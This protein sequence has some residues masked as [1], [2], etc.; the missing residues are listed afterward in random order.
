[1]NIS[2][3]SMELNDIFTPNG[4]PTATYV[5][6]S[7]GHL[8]KKLQQYSQTKNIVVS[9]SG[10][11][12]TGKTVLIRKVL[13][14][15]NAILIPGASI[16][17]TNDFY[18]SAFEWLDIQ[19]PTGE[20]VS[21]AEGSQ[22]KIGATVKVDAPYLGGA[23]FSGEIGG[24]GSIN[25]ST[26]SAISNNPFKKLVESAT[27]RNSIIFID[28]FHYIPTQTQIELARI[29]KALA[30]NGVRIFTASVPHRAE[31]VVRANPELRGRFAGIDTMIWQLDELEKIAILG[32]EALNVSIDPS[33]AEKL[34]VFA[35][36]SPQIMH[37]LCLNLCHELGIQKN[38]TLRRKVNISNENIKNMLAATAD[39]T[40]SS[41]LIETLH[42]GPKVKGQPRMQYSFT[43][44]T[45]GDVY[46][47]ILLGIS[48]DPVQVVFSYDEI[49]N[50]V[51]NICKNEYPTGQSISQSLT[52]LHK[53]VNTQN[54]HQSYFE[55]DD[56]NLYITDPHLAFYLR[57]SSKIE[58]LGTKI[59]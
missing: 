39:F 12:K 45:K 20:T 48:K 5:A 18:G 8:E 25:K 24:S 36:G 59:R 6:R 2:L 19:T 4:Q 51:K 41:K 37:T 16:Q 7:D 47:A 35:H 50:R 9:L 58:N 29:I 21:Y 10:P 46:R 11:S 30:E 44:N 33:I 26:T 13:D 14:L 40:N 54:S 56:D 1:M 3:R 34:A 38:S 28:D 22:A 31:D 15:N 27:K 49:I 42:A 23:N 53:I 52:H 32:F 43:D 55:W 57:Y 17:T